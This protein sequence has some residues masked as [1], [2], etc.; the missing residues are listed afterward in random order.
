MDSRSDPDTSVH[1]VRWNDNSVVTVG[2]TVWSIPHWRGFS[3]SKQDRQQI[4]VPIPRSIVVYNKKMGGT[5]RMDKNIGYYRPGLRIR[6]WWWPLFIIQLS[7]A[8][9]TNHW[10]FLDLPVTW[11]GRYF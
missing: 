5:D 9:L 8:L 10:T 4:Q 7:C 11:L 3:W 2:S 1:I 6:K